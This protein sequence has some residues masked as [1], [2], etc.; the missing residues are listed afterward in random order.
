MQ[1]HT[2]LAGLLAL[3]AMFGLNPSTSP[4][5]FHGSSRMGLEI[6]RFCQAAAMAGTSAAKLTEDELV[7]NCSEKLNSSYLKQ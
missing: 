3:R 2:H 7:V 4:G 6:S 5:F 1:P